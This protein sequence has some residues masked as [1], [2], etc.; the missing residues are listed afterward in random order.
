[1]K[2]HW[3]GWK[4]KLSCS[5]LSMLIASCMAAQVHADASSN[6]EHELRRLLEERDRVITSLQQKI[7]QLEGV[8]IVPAL[9][10]SRRNNA[11][12]DSAR[13]PSSTTSTL[14]IDPLTAER[15]LER[16]LTQ[17]GA[18]LLPAGQAE[19]QIG[20]AYARTQQSIFVAHDDQRSSGTLDLRRN[21]YSATLSTRVG[22]PYDAQL[23]MTVPYRL[24]TQSQI[25]SF[26]RNAP[27]EAHNTAPVLGDISTGIAKTLLHEQG[28]RPDVIGRLTWNAGN[29][30]EASHAI[31]I[32]DGFKKIRS[33]LTLLK[34]Q[35]PLVFAGSVSY[36]STFKKNT[37]KPGDQLGV[38]LSALLATSPD[39]SMSMGIDQSF[40]KKTRINGITIAGSDQ[41][42]GML[43]LGATSMVGKHTL[44]SIN[45][46]KGL[47]K[48]APDYFI[49]V[50]VPMRFELFK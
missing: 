44:L 6:A 39:T 46:G 32:G 7:T 23:E 8:S 37:V 21:D 13:T 29:G 42:S 11:A 19:L 47:T 36:E 20:A 18:L 50:A 28:W 22:L 17:S 5:A 14:N 45:M 12:N 27:H 15:A 33:E 40:S 41:V 49:S 34:R 38:S 35:D 24:V 31:A 9:M 26:D 4:Y 16:T 48:G 10:E 1:M 25:T 3:S 30:R 2:L 43:M